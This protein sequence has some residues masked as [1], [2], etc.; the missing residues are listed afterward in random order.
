MPKLLTQLTRLSR[1]PKEIATF[2]GNP[3]RLQATFKTP[4]KELDRFVATLLK[5]VS[6]ES[7]V[8]S[9]DL[10]VFEP[11]HL[12]A[13]LNRSSIQV[14]DSWHLNLR[15]E[16]QELVTE[17][18]VAALADWTDFVFIPSPPSFAIYA[19]HDEY[20]TFYAKARANLKSLQ[21]RLIAGGFKHIDGYIRSTGEP[22]N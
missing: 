17:L 16:S 1:R 12:I 6:A 10:V 20:V 18:L 15:A 21:T 5:P 4:L 9:L 19:D 2:C 14:D 22:R 7:A 3:W 11:K 8:L 13:L